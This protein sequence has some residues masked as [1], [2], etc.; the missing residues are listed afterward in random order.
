MG[1][2]P[3]QFLR[4]S[5]GRLPF[6]GDK[7]DGEAITK[8]VPLASPGYRPAGGDSRAGS[9]PAGASSAPAGTEARREE[10]ASVDFERGPMT[11]VII[12]SGARG[13]GKTTLINGI[14]AANALDEPPVVLECEAGESSVSWDLISAGRVSLWPVVPARRADAG[15]GLPRTLHQGLTTI[16][17]SSPPAC[18]IVEACDAAS[19]DD[20]AGV[21]SYVGREQPLEVCAAITVVDTT[22]VAEPRA[23]S[24]AACRKLEEARLL[25]LT[26]AE[27]LSDYDVFRVRGILHAL[28]DAPVVRLDSPPDY[29]RLLELAKVA[30]AMR[31]GA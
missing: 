12:I 9:M 28:V 10:T 19:V 3:S 31:G 20:V 4:N 25:V 17:R 15:D 6:A 7:D 22:R 27:G 18:V 14:V 21:V 13:A 30:W 26:K 2:G 16:M 24:N 1:A 11:E 23:L 8:R 29:R 5:F